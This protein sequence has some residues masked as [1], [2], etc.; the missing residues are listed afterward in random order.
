MPGGDGPVTDSVVARGPASEY[1][2][3]RSQPSV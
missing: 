3:G 2:R 1:P